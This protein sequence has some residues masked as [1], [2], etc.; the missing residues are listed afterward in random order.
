[1][2]LNNHA[3]VSNVKTLTAINASERQGTVQSIGTASAVYVI[4]L[5]YVNFPEG[6]ALGISHRQFALH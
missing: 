5:I 4:E 6:F 1:M 2:K 3:N